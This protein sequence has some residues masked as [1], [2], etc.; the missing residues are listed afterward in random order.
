MDFPCRLC[1]RRSQSQG[2][3]QH[4]PTEMI[5]FFWS[6]IREIQWHPKLLAVETDWNP[7]WITYSVYIYNHVLSV[8]FKH[9]IWYIHI[10]CFFCWWA[11]IGLFWTIDRM[12]DL[13][14]ELNFMLQDLTLSWAN[15][16]WLDGTGSKKGWGPF[17]YENHTF[18]LSKICTIYMGD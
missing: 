13:L 11:I 4:E 14:L 8:F 15:Q 6:K 2:P 17:R 16:R 12:Q 5:T 7:K 3:A 1:P 9:I 18:C 10:R